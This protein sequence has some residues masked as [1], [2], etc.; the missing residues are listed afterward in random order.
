MGIV[1]L[2]PG[3]GENDRAIWRTP[4]ADAAVPLV[5]PEFAKL[6]YHFRLGLEKTK[7]S[8][9]SVSEPRPT[10][11]VDPYARWREV[12]TPP[13]ISLTVGKRDAGESSL[14]YMLLE[15]FRYQPTPFLVGAPAKAEKLLPPWIGI[16]P[17]IE[18]LPHY[19][20]ALIDEA[21]LFYHSRGS[22][23]ACPPAAGRRRP[24]LRPSPSLTP[25][26]QTPGGASPG[27]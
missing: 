14:N 12:I 5:F 6:L 18:D 4:G 15:A 23:A 3:R 20:I 24:W 1:S 25:A 16:V 22:G 13:A 19:S 17:S 27:L 9:L 11:P 7:Q 8:P 26:G 2:S 21:Y 10:P